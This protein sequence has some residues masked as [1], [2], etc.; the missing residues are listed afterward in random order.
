MELLEG[1]TRDTGVMTPMYLL[2]VEEYPALN[3]S[4]LNTIALHLA[5]SYGALLRYD[6]SLGEFQAMFDMGYDE[7]ML[8]I[9]PEISTLGINEALDWKTIGDGENHGCLCI[10]PS[11]VY[12]SSSS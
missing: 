5:E 7:M 3:P 12:S 6:A 9:E 11:L 4:L 2:L 1:W 10:K 8:Q